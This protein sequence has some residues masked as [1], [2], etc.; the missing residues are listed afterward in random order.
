MPNSST[1]TQMFLIHNWNQGINN[2]GKTINALIVFAK[3]SMS[4]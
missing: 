4:T 2:E 1:Y 3:L